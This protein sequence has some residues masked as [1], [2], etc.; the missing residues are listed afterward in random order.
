MEYSEIRLLLT[1]Y[2][3][4]KNEAEN[5][6][7]C[8]WVK[9]KGECN[10]DEDEWSLRLYE[11]CWELLRAVEDLHADISEL[12]EDNS[13]LE[14]ANKEL[15]EENKNLSLGNDTYKLRLEEYNKIMEERRRTILA[16]RE[17]GRQQ[18]LEIYHKDVRIAKL[19]AK[20]KALSSEVE[21][22]VW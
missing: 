18:S 12:Q 9:N 17:V 14:Q 21:E 13:R 6:N 4:C 16:Q 20:L 3:H 5:C 1:T 22:E 11:A 15:V 2:S 19:T 10:F 7:D 8:P